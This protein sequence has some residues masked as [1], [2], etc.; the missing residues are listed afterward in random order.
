MKTRPLESLVLA[1]FERLRSEGRRHPEIDITAM[2]YALAG[3]RERPRG[4]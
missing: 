4:L 3:A 2:A 1:E